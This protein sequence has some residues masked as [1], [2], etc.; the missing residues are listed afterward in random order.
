MSVLWT[1]IS[2]I[3]NSITPNSAM[4]GA[5]IIDVLTNVFQTGPENYGKSILVNIFFGVFFARVLI[6]TG[7]AATLI[8]K[9]VELG[10]DKPRITMSLLCIVTTIIFT[11]MTGIGPVISI[12]VIVLPIMLSLGIPAPIAM[13]SF[14]GSIMAGYLVISLTLSSIRRY[15]QRQMKVMAPTITIPIFHLE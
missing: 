4:E 7:I 2:L 12:A 6:D 13:F 5:T 9:V 1:T 8:R 10:G 15:L 11:S 3:G 14:M